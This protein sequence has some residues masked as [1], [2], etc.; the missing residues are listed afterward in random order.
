M[1]ESGG[2]AANDFAE[3]LSGVFEVFSHT[4]TSWVD[5]IGDFIGLFPIND[6]YDDK[7]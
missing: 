7:F 2:L 1:R 6:P 3:F 5:I 4:S